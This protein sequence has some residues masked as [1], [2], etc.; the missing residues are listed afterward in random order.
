MTQ[1]YKIISRKNF[2]EQ[3]F[4]PNYENASDFE[5]RKCDVP[6]NG[7]SNHTFE[8]LSVGNY[9]GIMLKSKKTSK[10]ET[11]IETPHIDEQNKQEPSLNICINLNILEEHFYPIA[12]IQ[13][14]K[15]HLGS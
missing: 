12:K 1:Y 5:D 8:N 14:L 11:F 7:I 9:V 3:G 6:L 2:I 10:Y 13:N 15:I 4:I